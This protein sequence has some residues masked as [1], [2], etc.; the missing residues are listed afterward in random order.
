MQPFLKPAYL[1][2]DQMLLER[3][4]PLT[5]HPALYHVGLHRLILPWLG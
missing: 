4:E 1:S 5:E 3:R 2:K